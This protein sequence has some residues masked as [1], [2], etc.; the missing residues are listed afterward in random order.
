M[1]KTESIK[2]VCIEWE[3]SVLIGKE[4]INKDS[5]EIELAKGFSCGVLVKEDKEKICLATDYFTTNSFSDNPYRTAQVY[6][7]SGIKKIHRLELK[8]IKI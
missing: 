2:I 3:D 5:P 7:K 8:P 6:P 4:Q 1:K